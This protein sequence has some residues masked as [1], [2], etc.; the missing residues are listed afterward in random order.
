MKYTRRHGST[1]AYCAPLTYAMGHHDTER[2]CIDGPR[3][4]K[5]D[6]QTMVV[7]SLPTFFKFAHVA[8]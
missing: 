6:F 1:C 8:Q 2:A 4:S 3:F 5:V 7:F